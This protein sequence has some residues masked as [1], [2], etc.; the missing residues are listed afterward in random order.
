V[1]A[2][3]G[4]SSGP[5][6]AVEADRTLCASASSGHSRKRHSL[7]S[8]RMPRSGTCVRLGFNTMPWAVRLPLPPRPLP[9]LDPTRPAHPPRSRP[10]RLA[11]RQGQRHLRRFQRAGEV[12][13][14]RGDVAPTGGAGR[15]ADQDDPEIGYH[16]S[17]PRLRPARRSRPRGPDRTTS[18]AGMVSV[19]GRCRRRRRAS[20][21]RSS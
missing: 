11:P 3:C 20:S 17:T 14:L 1:A 9:S 6:A 2:G 10:R 19:P 12:G 5:A 4:R 13:D 21:P 8:V 16:P 15:A 7:A 18:A